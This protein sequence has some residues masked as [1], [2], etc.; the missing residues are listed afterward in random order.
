MSPNARARRKLA[1]RTIPVVVIVPTQ[2]PLALRWDQPI[3][4]VHE[5]IEPDPEAPALLA[6]RKA[7]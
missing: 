7:A 3:D 6:R 5:A 1:G 4:H 2:L